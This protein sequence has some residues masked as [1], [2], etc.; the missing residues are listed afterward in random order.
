MSARALALVSKLP[1]ARPSHPS[2]LRNHLFTG[3][4][5][6]LRPEKQD[7]SNESQRKGFSVE[8]SGT[9]FLPLGWLSFGTK[10]DCTSD[11]CESLLSDIGAEGQ[12]VRP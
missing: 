9:V 6:G 2:F 1:D 4:N 3:K 11:L 5:T 10:P 12:D 8:R 7:K